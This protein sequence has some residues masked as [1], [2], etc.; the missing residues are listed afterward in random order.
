MV[1]MDLFNDSGFSYSSKFISF[2]GISWRDLSYLLELEGTLIV[3][4]KKHLTNTFENFY[5]NVSPQKSCS[6]QLGL[7]L[8]TDAHGS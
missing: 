7:A 8:L 4:L 2:E 1:I 3:V 5:N 6:E